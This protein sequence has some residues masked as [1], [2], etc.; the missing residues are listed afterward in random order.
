LDWPEHKVRASLDIFSLHPREK[1]LEPSHPFKKEDVYPWR[2]NRPLA[3][4]RKPFLQRDKQGKRQIICGARHLISSLDFLTYLCSIGRFPAQTQLMK[5]FL[6]KLNNKRGR[7]FNDR[8]AGFFDT[9][10][11]FNVRKNIKKIPG[12]TGLRD[13]GEIDVI[14]AE[15][16]KRILWV[17]ECKVLAYARTPHE[18]ALELDGMFKGICG[19]PSMLRRL[20]TKSEWM[21]KNIRLVLQWIGISI[22][23]PWAVKPMLITDR[24]VFSKWIA[25]D[26]VP[27]EAFVKFKQRFT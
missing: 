10:P 14:V 8:V 19:K 4:V 17:I 25:E 7:E 9:K 27:V 1:F 18:V 6:S 26:V 23:K 22:D 16:A 20:Q 11:S 2:Y 21:E 24:E 15:A 13:L 5:Q 12:T 3:Y